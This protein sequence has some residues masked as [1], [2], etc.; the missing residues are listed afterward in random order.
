[1]ATLR[2][3]ARKLTRPVRAVEEA[4]SQAWFYVRVFEMIPFTIRRYP[5]EV[6]RVLAELSFSTGALA[7]VGGTV[8]ITAFM[9]AFAG[10]ELG[11]Q[12][13]DQLSNIGIEA[14]AGFTSAY[15]NT[16]LGVPLIAG[17]TLVATIGA[18]FTAQL[19]AMRVSEEID[20][21]EVI[22]V[23]S[24]P[25]LVTTRVI[26]GLVAIIPIYCLSMLSCWMATKVIVTVFFGQ[27]VGAYDHYFFVFL[28]PQD[29][30]MSLVMAMIM[31]VVI[32]SIC[33]YYGY[34][35]HGGPAGVG[36]AVGRAVR[37]ALIAVLFTQ[38]LMSMVLYGNADTLNISG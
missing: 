18:G 30:F 11:V 34:Y 35:A 20:A 7:V 28:I 3:V 24:V 5:R 26:A 21:L 15:L 33:C 22:A 36:L 32:M 16:R 19:G 1:M 6:L 17:V 9:T 27:S 2:P 10:I 4:G 12:G 31:S 25:F 23:Q 8:V 37:L 14:L 29:I 13:Y 38:L